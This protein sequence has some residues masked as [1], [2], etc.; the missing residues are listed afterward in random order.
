MKYF[1]IL[2]QGEK[3]WIYTTCIFL[4]LLIALQFLFIGDATRLY[5]SYVDRL[6]GENIELVMPLEAIK[7]SKEEGK[8]LVVARS[9]PFMKQKRIMKIRVV[10]PRASDAI[11]FII[12]GQPAGTFQ[13]GELSVTVFD[14]DYAEID[15][16]EVQ[17]TARYIVQVAEQDFIY[18][19]DGMLF[20]T[21]G[22]VVPIGKIKFR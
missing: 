9:F 10:E 7:P 2:A 21:E 19:E 8:S 4:F 11:R 16:T 13:T 14:S 18:P 12:N 5:V 20:E 1:Q 3:A 22:T 15:A 17:E 6:E